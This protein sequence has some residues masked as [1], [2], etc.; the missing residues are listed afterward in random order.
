MIAAG[1]ENPTPDV[2]RAIAEAE[3]T[4]KGGYFH[5][6]YT[7]LTMF[8]T[9]HFSSSTI[10]PITLNVS[11]LLIDADKKPADNLTK[12]AA[13]DID[14]LLVKMQ[15]IS[16]GVLLNVQQ[17]LLKEWGPDSLGVLPEDTMQELLTGVTFYC[18]PF[19]TTHVYYFSYLSL[20]IILI[21]PLLSLLLYFQGLNLLELAVH[22]EEKA[23]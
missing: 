2:S 4:S 10:T 18:S 7:S 5:I 20:P 23:A 13:L 6:F 19:L 16:K 22:L 11:H 8:K 21:A 9:F 3:A 14:N 17:T 15:S 12:L 1:L